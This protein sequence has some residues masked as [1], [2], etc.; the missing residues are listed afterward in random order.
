MGRRRPLGRKFSVCEPRSQADLYWR[1]P[2]AGGR[3]KNGEGRDSVPD[4]SGTEF[5]RVGNDRSWILEGQKSRSVVGIE[6][7]GGS[8]Q[9]FQEK[10]NSQQHCCGYNKLGFV[11]VKWSDISVFERFSDFFF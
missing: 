11:F 1:L 10:L 3:T 6:K 8:H 5:R 7:Q 4:P 9:Y 2:P